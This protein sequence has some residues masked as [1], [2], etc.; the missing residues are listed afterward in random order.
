MQATSEFIITMSTELVLS[1]STKMEYTEGFGS[2][3][4]LSIV[5]PQF[6]HNSKQ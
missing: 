3:N 2:A 6:K 5:T 4:I 1:K